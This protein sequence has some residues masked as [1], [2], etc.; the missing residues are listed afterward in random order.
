MGRV[1]VVVP[2]FDEADLLPSCLQALLGQDYP[3][4]IE[5]LVVDNASTDHTARVAREHGVRVIH[6]PR[7]GYC[8]ALRRGFGAAAGEIVA[9]T[10]ADSLVPADWISSIVREYDRDSNLVALG[11]EIDYWDSTWKSRLF[12]RV[13]IPLVNRIDRANPKGPHLWGANLSVRRSAFIAAGGWNPKFSL[14]ADSELSE[15]MRRFGRVAVLESLRV[16]TSARRWN[17]ALLVNAFIFA[18]NFIWYHLFR[19][20]LYREFPAVRGARGRPPRAR[21]RGRRPRHVIAATAA[22]VAVLAG[23][24]GYD[25]LA[26]RSDAFG[27]TYWC[28]PTRGKVV[29]LTFDD[30]P[31]EPY[32]SR[33]LDILERERVRATFFMIGSNVRRYPRT[34]AR[35]VRE[36]HV[37]GN[38]SDSHPVGFALESVAELRKELDAAE[39]SIHAAAG[40]YPRFFRPPQGLRSP[41]LMS[42]LRRDSLV[43]VT[44]NDAPGD[45]NH[46]PASALVARTLAQVHP[47]SIIL[48]HDGMNLTHGADQTATVQALPEI[49]RRLRA[50]GYRFCTVPELLRDRSF[51]VRWPAAA[52]PGPAKGSATGASA[53][54]RTL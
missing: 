3:G 20:P 40:V 39:E 1:S 49:I 41:W 43:A 12:T 9:C 11:G 22:S 52:V 47:G 54:R 53:L 33:I 21:P 29:A 35:A 16:R 5:I 13:I 44:W 2:A 17:R 24:V 37:I 25:A 36:G 34:A 42:L 14:Q 8:N 26:P 27:R 46:V 48:L 6:E 32:T 15:R 23:I 7:R 4:E 38:H 45:W 18:S 19:G 51:L 31:N 30:G 28:G 50:L 10:D